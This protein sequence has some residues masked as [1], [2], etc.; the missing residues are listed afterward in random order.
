[1]LPKQLTEAEVNSIAKLAGVERVSPHVLRH[2]AATH[3]LRRGVPIWQVAG[4]LA[5]TVAMV[6]KIYGH[7]VPDGVREWR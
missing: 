7:H 4:I 1:M 5:N 3:M 2:A 6:E